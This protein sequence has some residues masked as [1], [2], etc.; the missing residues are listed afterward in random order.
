M[1]V[2]RGDIR[3]ALLVRVKEQVEINIANRVAVAE[4]DIFVS[5]ARYERSAAYKRVN[6][7]CKQ[8]AGILCGVERRQ[9]EHTLALAG[10][11]PRLARAEVIH[12]RTVVALGYNADLGDAGVDHI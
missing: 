1:A 4:Q 12:Q 3:T 10:K 2:C 8:S 5:R 11:I 6:S 9:N 7:V